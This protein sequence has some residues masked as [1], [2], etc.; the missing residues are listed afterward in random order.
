MEGESGA[1]VLDDV[2]NFVGLDWG[3]SNIGK[4]A[5][6]IPIGHVMIEARTRKDVEL[7]QV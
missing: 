2:G 1:W 5:N 6:V 7:F 3:L 4:S